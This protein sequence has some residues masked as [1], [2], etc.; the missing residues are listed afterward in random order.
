MEINVRSIYSSYINFDS[1]SRLVDLMDIMEAVG[2]CIANEDR[3][4][5]LEVIV[6]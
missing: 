4:V 6:S 1:L 5:I 2:G 3:D